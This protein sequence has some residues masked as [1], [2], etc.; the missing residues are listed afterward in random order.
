MAQVK[1]LGK[2]EGLGELVVCNA[3][4]DKQLASLKE[5]GVRYPITIRD[6]AYARLHNGPLDGTRT[7]HAP[8]YA[9]DSP[10]Y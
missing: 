1:S 9:K 5:S 2:I 6:T 7:C 4:F 8:L 10:K 3:P